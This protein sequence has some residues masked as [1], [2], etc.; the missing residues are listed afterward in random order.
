MNRNQET[1]ETLE[2]INVL[3]LTEGIGRIKNTVFPLIMNKTSG[4]LKE[5]NSEINL[6]NS[7]LFTSNKFL[8]RLINVKGE[9]IND[10]LLNHKLLN[11]IIDLEDNI[12]QLE[13]YKRIIYQHL[14]NVNDNTELYL[15]K[16]INCFIQFNNRINEETIKN[17]LNVSLQL[18]YIDLPYKNKFLKDIGK[19]HDIKSIYING[20]ENKIHINPQILDSK[21]YIK[22]TLSEFLNAQ[23]IDIDQIIQ[24]LHFGMCTLDSLGDF[25]VDLKSSHFTEYSDEENLNIMQRKSRNKGE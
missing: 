9:L 7:N 13:N 8:Y 4:Q 11:M 15:S 5:K 22:L 24:N 2:N 6:F 16:Y 14:P 23:Y 1:Q 12:Q 3:L 21:K 20:L 10:T 17:I 18:G 19:N 25:K